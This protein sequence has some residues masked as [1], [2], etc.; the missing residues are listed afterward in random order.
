MSLHTQASETGAVIACE[1]EPRTV[2]IT[3]NHTMSQSSRSSWPYC[4]FMQ[5]AP[6]SELF[7]ILEMLE[8]LLSA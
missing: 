1:Q 6:D 8:T 3:D 5:D 2:H 7:A 4:S